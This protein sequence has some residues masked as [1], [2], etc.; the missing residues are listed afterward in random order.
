M[1][2]HDPLDLHLTPGKIIPKLPFSWDPQNEFPGVSLD[3]HIF[4]WHLIVL[5]YE[6]LNLPEFSSIS[7][8]RSF[9]VPEWRFRGKM[10]LTCWVAASNSGR[11]PRQKNVKNRQDKSRQFFDNVC[12]G[13]GKRTQGLWV[14]GRQL[15]GGGDVQRAVGEL[16][17]CAGGETRVPF[18]VAPSSG[19]KMK[20]KP[21]LFD[22]DIFGWGGGL[23]REGVGAKKFGMSFETQGNQTCWRDI[24]GFMAG[25]PGGRPKSLRQKSCVQPL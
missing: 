17:F 11:G 3:R 7:V 14:E 12:T 18:Q 8:E 5:Q 24:P 13:Q 19:K 4:A 10:K 15:G 6:T 21:K 23:P 16:F 22:P 2:S 9:A 20:P 25:Y 1:L